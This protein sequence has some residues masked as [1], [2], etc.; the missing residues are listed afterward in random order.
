M[1]KP[2]INQDSVVHLEL[3]AEF[4]EKA[5]LLVPR[6]H[7]S[8]LDHHHQIYTHLLYLSRK[9]LA[10]ALYHLEPLIF[11]LEFIILWVST[12]NK[13]ALYYCTS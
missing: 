10:A 2:V 1:Q 6:E 12:L 11:K 5:G 8:R 13:N 7:K 9:H 4:N 3:W